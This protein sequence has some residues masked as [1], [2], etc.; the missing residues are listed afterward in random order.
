[1]NS[2]LATA[3][4]GI[5]IPTL[6]TRP[7]YLKLA[8]ESIRRASEEAVHILIVAPIDF[9]LPASL[10]VDQLSVDP[11]MG[12]AAA[13]NCGIRELPESIEFINWL[14]DDDLLEVGAIDIAYNALAKSAVPFVFGQ[15]KYINGQGELLFINKSGRWAT[16]LMRVGPQLIPQPGALFRRSVFRS[17]GELDSQYKWA[18]DLDMF[19]KMSFAGRP[20]FLPMV[21]ASFRWHNDS[22]SVGGRKGSVLEAS[23]VRKK[24][25]PMFLRRI[26]FLWEPLIRQVIFRVGQNIKT[27]KES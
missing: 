10:E 19:I 25:L 11:G 21:L 3:R 18:F 5:V 2:P 9:S 22:L 12:L 4:V 6:G 15:C 20:I 16:L 8:I 23:L 1:M 27:S 17:I 7:D 26:S 24:H 13:I 14:G